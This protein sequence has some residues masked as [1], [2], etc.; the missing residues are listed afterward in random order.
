MAGT[1]PVKIDGFG[2]IWESPEKSC[3]WRKILQKIS[4]IMTTKAGTG[5]PYNLMQG[6]LPNS[7]PGESTGPALQ[8]PGS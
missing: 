3:L 4:V 1:G 2:F 7:G 6:R 8:T 5:K